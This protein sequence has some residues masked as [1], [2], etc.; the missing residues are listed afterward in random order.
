MD[1]TIN[2]GGLIRFGQKEHILDLFENGLVYCNTI[3]YFR[4]LE[5]KARGDRYE[6]TSRITN[7]VH[8]TNFELTFPDNSHPPLKLHPKSFHLREFYDNPIGNLYCLFAVYTDEI[9]KKGI[10]KIDMKMNQFEASHFIII[11]TPGEFIRRIREELQKLNYEY[12]DGLVKYYNKQTF[13]GTLTMFD[14][15]DEYAYQNEFRFLIGNDGQKPLIL[16]LGSLK[17]IS[18]VLEA[19]DLEHLEFRDISKSV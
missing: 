12:K 1:N 17:D 11:H 9:R 18:L 3:K 2:I 8:I 10:Y 4:E 15:S 7:S 5:N 6:G 16:K 14:K 13:N 19:K